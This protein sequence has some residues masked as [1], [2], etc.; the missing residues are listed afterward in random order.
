MEV[1]H[2]VFERNLKSNY[3]FVFNYPSNFKFQALLGGCSK[4]LHCLM[5]SRWQGFQESSGTSLETRS[6]IFGHHPQRACLLGRL[7]E[8]GHLY[9]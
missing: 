1:I 9:G 5:R 7:G 6:P 3:Y 2:L 4:G 8:E